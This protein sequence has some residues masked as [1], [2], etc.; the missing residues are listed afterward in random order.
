[1]T[2]SPLK[3]AKW[4]NF[5]CCIVPKAGFTFRITSKRRKR[6]KNFYYE[7]SQTINGMW[8]L[9]KIEMAPPRNTFDF[10]SFHRDISQF[11][12][13]FVELDEFTYSDYLIAFMRFLVLCDWCDLKHVESSHA[14]QQCCP[15]DKLKIA[16]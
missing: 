7:A 16:L 12:L 13:G 14:F 1:M 10:H 9:T 4:L 6:R 11:F 2:L 8:P 15:A 5:Y 3:Q